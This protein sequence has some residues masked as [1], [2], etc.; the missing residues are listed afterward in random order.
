M[1]KYAYILSED[2]KHVRVDLIEHDGQ[3]FFNELTFTTHN[4]N[5][6]K[7]FNNFA[8]DKNETTFLN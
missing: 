3:I 4:G 8:L 1:I 6:N 7:T 5:S 2:F